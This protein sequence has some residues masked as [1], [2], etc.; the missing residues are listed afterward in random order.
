[1]EYLLIKRVTQ[2]SLTRL[3]ATDDARFCIISLV[4]GI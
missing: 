1:M 3:L 4:G 2:L